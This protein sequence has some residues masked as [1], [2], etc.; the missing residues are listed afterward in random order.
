MTDMTYNVQEIASNAQVAAETATSASE[1]I[2]E[3][4]KR[5]EELLEQMKQYPEFCRRFCKCYP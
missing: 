1:L 2:Q 5:S 3:L 4:G